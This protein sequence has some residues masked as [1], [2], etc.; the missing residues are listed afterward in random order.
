MIIRHFALDLI[1][2]ELDVHELERDL[3]PYIKNVAAWL[4]AHS[5]PPTGAH[6]PLPSDA[7]NKKID[8]I[9]EIEQEMHSQT[10]G[11]KGR[12]DVTLKVSAYFKW[13]ICKL[14]SIF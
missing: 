10:F 12:I 3:Q 4:L 8:R 9:A 5:P 2:M 1:I 13:K 11:I 14:T 6:L 7:P